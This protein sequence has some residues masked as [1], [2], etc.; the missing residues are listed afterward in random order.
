ML[1][2]VF[3][4]NGEF[5]YYSNYNRINAKGIKEEI[6][7]ELYKRYSSRAK[8]YEIINFIRID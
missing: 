6:E 8:Y 7:N 5:E 2:R 3:Y 4:T 1:V